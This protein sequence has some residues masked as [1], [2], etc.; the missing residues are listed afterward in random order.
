MKKMLVILGPT[1]TGKTDLALSL[2]KIFDGELVA[3]DSRQV[4]QGLNVGTGKMPSKNAKFKIKNQKWEIDEIPVHMY[5]VADPKIQFTVKDYVKKS[6]QVV[7]DILRRK[8]LPII[9]GGTGLYL[10]AL[11]EGLP[12]LEIP[13]DQKLRGELEKLSL[14]K[15]QNKLQLLSP[16]TWKKLNNSDRNNKRRILRSIELIHMYPYM[17]PRNKRKMINDK[18]NVLKIGLT[19]PRQVLYEKIDRRL[20]AQI[21]QGLIKEGKTL[22]QKGL[23]LKRMRQLGL[24]YGILADLLEGKI[25]QEQFTKILSTK[26]HQYAKRQQTW[27]KKEKDVLWFNISTLDMSEKVEKAVTS[28]YHAGDDK[29]N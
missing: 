9:V 14:E 12:N 17:R 15:L 19:A 6:E 20:I 29:K 4:Y 21:D 1:A 23:T 27:F 10:K 3:C 24:E 18:Y 2:A 5:D 22:R 25:N 28:W 13:V 11:L 8:K 26:I 7:E 16:T